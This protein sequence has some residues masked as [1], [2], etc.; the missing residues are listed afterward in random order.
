MGADHAA[1]DQRFGSLNAGETRV[2]ALPP[3]RQN[4]ITEL[5]RLSGYDLEQAYVDDQVKFHQDFV[6]SLDQRL[7]PNARSEQLKAALRSLRDEAA[8]HL[9]RA[10]EFRVSITITSPD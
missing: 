2:H 9:Q 7:I 8:A 4:E 1:I 3:E 10:S 6:S 5:Q